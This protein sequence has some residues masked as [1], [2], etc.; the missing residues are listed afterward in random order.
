MVSAPPVHLP[1]SFT[2]T[3]DQFWE[4]A[5][6]NPELR[7]ERT[8]E[9]ELIVMPPTVSEGGNYNAEVTTEFGIAKRNWAESLIHQQDSS[10]PMVQHEHPIRP[11]LRTNDGTP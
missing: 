2:V 6:T 7:L 3:D 1:R 9:G 10:C 11:G 5:R 4:L 8:A